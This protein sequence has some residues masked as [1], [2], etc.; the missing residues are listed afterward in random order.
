MTRNLDELAKL[1]DGLRKALL[2]LGE[3]YAEPVSL[4]QLA[5][6]AH[7][8]PS[9][10]S[11]LFR[12]TLS[13]SFKPLLQRMRVDKAK[14]LL[15]SGARHRITEVAMSVGFGD[16]SH[17][18]KSFRRIVGQSPRDYRRGSEPLP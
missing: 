17:F 12:S 5:R 16:L 2:Y 10:L 15:G 7:V 1:H 18:E 8:S 14:E 11:F 6:Q 4:D 13:T 3:H 9:H